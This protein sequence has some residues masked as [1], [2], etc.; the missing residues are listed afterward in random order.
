ET[1]FRVWAMVLSALWLLALWTG[2]AL[3]DALG[4]VLN[5]HGHSHLHAH[6]HP[7]VDARTLL[8]L[9][10]ALDVVSN[11][12]LSLAGLVGLWVIRGRVLPGA[13]QAAL[14]VFFAGL[15]LT[16]F[17]SAWYH[18]AP[19]AAGLV[20]DRLGMAVTFAG[21]LALAVAERVEQGPARATLVV[22]FAVAV[23]SS[24]LPL[25]HA[26]VLPWAVV[27]FGSVVLIAWAAMQQP[28]SGAIGVRIGALLAWYALAKALEMGDESVFHA[29]GEWVSGHSLKHIAAALAAVPVITRVGRQPFAGECPLSAQTT[30]TR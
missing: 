24:V 8:G 5:P 23:C 19:D 6:G 26:N 12:P 10:N 3:L 9:P 17:G 16:G 1:A 25:T 22:A 29:T 18:W 11:A 13:T 4:F 30:T 7:F 15:L 14:R 27:Q 20:C 2:P 21:A 28:A